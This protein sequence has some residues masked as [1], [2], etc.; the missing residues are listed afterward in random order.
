MGPRDY[1]ALPSYSQHWYAGI[2]PFKDN[3]QI[4]ACNPLKLREYLAAGR[5]IVSTPFPA[6]APFSELI[7]VATRAEQFAAALES[8]V[9]GESQEHKELRQNSVKNADWKV[10]AKIVGDVIAQL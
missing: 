9:R 1:Q 6:L 8:S 4:Q 10:K 3:R 5:P 2:L 7:H